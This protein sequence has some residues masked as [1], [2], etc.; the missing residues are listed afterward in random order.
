[1]KPIPQTRSG[2]LTVLAAGFMLSAALRAGDVVAGL[3]AIRD[4]GFGNRVAP[5]DERPGAPPAA[6]TGSLVS[7]LQRQAARLNERE[8]ALDARARELEAVEARLR[9][10]LDELEGLRRALETEAAGARGAA[11]EDVRQLANV[12]QA[13]KPKEAGRIF[14][15]MEPSF[16]AGFLGEL[17]VE[18]AASILSNMKPERAYAVSLLLAGRNLRADASAAPAVPAR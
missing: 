8:G 17:R 10:R 6:A 11:A 16:A 4:D 2:A 3:P 13:M 18:S 15:E 1:M 7:E 5:A 9:S 14:D 12:Y